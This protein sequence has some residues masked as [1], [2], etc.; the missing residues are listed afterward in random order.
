[1]M[2]KKINILVP[3]D[4]KE[5]PLTV[6]E[7]IS[8]LDRRDAMPHITLLHV[9]EFPAAPVGITEP[10]DYLGEFFQRHTEACEEKMKRLAAS[11]WFEGLPVTTRVVTDSLEGPAGCIASMALKGNFDL[12]V[13][14][15]RHRRGLQQLFSGSEL[16]RIVRLCHVPMILFSAQRMPRMNRIAFATDL[17]EAS[18][19]VYEQLLPLARLLGGRILPF[20]VNT[21]SSFQDQ[22]QF[23]AARNAFLNRIGPAE[24]AE[25]VS[26]NA[27]EVTDGIV[28]FA[29]DNVANF[30]A[31]GTHGRR[32]L[33]HLYHGSVTEEVIQGTTWPVIVINMQAQPASMH[34]ETGKPVTRLNKPA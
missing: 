15:S 11:S 17:S 18:A 25:V 13:L 1:M 28:Q 26:Y 27:N 3:V 21:V 10:A 30:I 32:G 8:A 33:S 14:W 9:V 4:F 22:R 6:L 31:L 5:E 7:F 19:W 23:I 2:M 34:K 16:L 29:E 24:N 20:C 12:V